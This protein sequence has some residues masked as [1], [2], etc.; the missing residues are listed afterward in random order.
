MDARVDSTSILP[1]NSIATDIPHV[2]IWCDG[3]CSPNPGAGG[4]GAVLLFGSHRKEI[5]EPIG[6]CTNNAAEIQAAITALMSLKKTCRVTIHSDSQYLVST[7]NGDFRKSTNLELW[8]A[9][10]SSGRDLHAGLV[11]AERLI[12]AKG[13]DVPL[14]TGRAVIA[15]AHQRALAR[16]QASALAETA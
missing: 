13:G 7:M 1:N 6:H 12:R 10:T 3:A 9:S 11:L 4:I 15:D 2:E 14:D 8:H 5:S 16:R